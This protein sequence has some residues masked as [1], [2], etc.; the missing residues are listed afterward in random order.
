MLDEPASSPALR[1]LVV[2]GGNR[3]IGAA[4]A[5]L[6][7][8]RGH[9]VAILYGQDAAKAR[10]VISGIESRGGRA[11]AVQADV[12]SGADVVR[13]FDD[14]ADRLGPIGALVNNAGITGGASLISDLDEARLDRLLAVNVAGPMLCAREAVR[15]MATDLGFQG[16]SIVNVSS[17]AACGGAPGVWVHYAATK[18]ALDTLTLGLSKEL[19]GRGIRVNAVRPGVIDTDIHD[20]RPAEQLA[21]MV[22][23]IPMQRMGRC[24]EVANAILWLISAEAS[25]VTGALLDVAGGA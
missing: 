14:I 2:T 10:E 16:G 13:A 19:A 23:N 6:A 4:C 5:T 7:A 18:G 15:R 24:D 11:I 25:Y 21:R 1:T 12:A 17:R 9:P 3:G 22:A 20:A 8:R